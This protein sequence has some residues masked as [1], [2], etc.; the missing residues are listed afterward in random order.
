M[1]LAQSQRIDELTMKTQENDSM[2]QL[3]TD[4]ILDIL[5]PRKGKCTCICACML[6]QIVYS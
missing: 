3:L 6:T 2:M 1:M 4:Q 5:S